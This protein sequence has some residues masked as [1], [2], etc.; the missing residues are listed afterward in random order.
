MIPVKGVKDE[1]G[2][3]SGH[4]FQLIIGKSWEESCKEDRLM[5]ADS[6]CP[7]PLP[8][9]TL[10]LS[11]VHVETRGQPWVLETQPFSHLD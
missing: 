4:G 10:L 2:P 5:F 9:H 6:P 3:T 11:F 1:K 7:A 8:L